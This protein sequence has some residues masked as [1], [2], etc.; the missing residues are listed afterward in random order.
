MGAVDIVVSFFGLE[1]KG[2]QI[3]AVIQS[4]TLFELLFKV[5]QGKR[6]LSCISA[7]QCEGVVFGA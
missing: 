4:I 7:S 1:C 2:T 3:D 6:S 5:K